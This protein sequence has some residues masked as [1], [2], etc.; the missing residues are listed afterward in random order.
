MMLWQGLTQIK[1]C[2]DGVLLREMMEDPL[3]SNYRCLEHHRSI[4]KLPGM[5]YMFAAASPKSMNIR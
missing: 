4:M 2:T 1:Y 3:L 5:L